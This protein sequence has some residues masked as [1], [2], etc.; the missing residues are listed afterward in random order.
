MCSLIPR[1]TCKPGTCS[2]VSPSPLW[3]PHL[4]PLQWAGRV[5]PED[6]HSWD[7][8]GC[9]ARGTQ[10]FHWRES[11]RGIQISWGSACP[12]PPAPFAQRQASPSGVFSHHP[13]SLLHPCSGSARP[14]SRPRQWALAPRLGAGCPG[15]ELNPSCSLRPGKDPNFRGRKS[16][17]RV[18][19]RGAWCSGGRPCL[20]SPD[21]CDLLPTGA[22]S[23][24]HPPAWGS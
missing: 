3:H 15:S 10:G 19:R 2:W 23:T 16:E 9:G 1:R 8:T 6:P 7:G 20:Y 21:L 12:P 4:L 14:G 11:R 18:G 24:A 5:S 17:E 22:W 13:L